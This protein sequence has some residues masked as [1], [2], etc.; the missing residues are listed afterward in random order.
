MTIQLSIIRIDG[1]G[2]WT[3][4]LGYDRESRLQ[5]LQSRIYYDIQRLFSQRE[6]IVYANRFDE[7][8]A[9]SN[10]LTIEDHLPI[11]EEL[12][13]IY[14]DLNLSIA[15]G[16]GKT[17]YQANLNAYKARRV[18][19]LRTGSHKI[20]ADDSIRYSTPIC[21]EN[22]AQITH[23]DIDGSSIVSN[24]LS[25]YEITFLITKA[26]ARLSEEFLKGDSLTFFLGGD[27]FMVISNGISKGRLLEITDIIIKDLGIKLN[28]G[29]G[30]G[31]TGRKAAA[32]A[33]RALD[34]I[35]DLRTKGKIQPI[36]EI[37]CL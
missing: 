27:N 15:V 14:S 36:Y 18:G 4:A 33:T 21:D 6:C 13:N 22:F 23:I 17:S 32:A 34:T 2:T 9:I 7:L 3:T 35:R 12:A 29:I 31:R 26:Y 25:P 11:L 5:M 8:F 20:F 19:R 16:S 37:R 24:E 1:Y 10:Y 30:V 28:C